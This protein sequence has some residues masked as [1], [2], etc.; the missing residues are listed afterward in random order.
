MNTPQF[1][2][3]ILVL[4]SCGGSRNQRVE[5]PAPEPHIQSRTLLGSKDTASKEA[6]EWVQSPTTPHR[7]ASAAATKGVGAKPPTEAMRAAARLQP[8]AHNRIEHF[9]SNTRLEGDAGAQE[10]VFHSVRSVAASSLPPAT[11]EAIRVQRRPAGGGSVESETLVLDVQGDVVLRTAAATPRPPFGIEVGGIL[12]DLR[13]SDDVLRMASMP[14][15]PLRLGSVVNMARCEMESKLAEVQ[16][17]GWQV[18]DL[19][20]AELG[21]YV[22]EGFQGGNPPWPFH[23]AS[24]AP[25]RIRDLRWEQG[26]EGI[27]WSAIVPVT[28]RGP[29]RA[30]PSSHD[31][32]M[33]GS[34]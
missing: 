12:I 9:Y 4:S 11:M 1:L 10:W 3:I 34:F 28:F 14:V 17:E 7:T 19:P 22:L 5:R 2:S 29:G 32:A 16:R 26:V 24:V 23:A 25:A 6:R 15:D 33:Q 31:M 21:L 27:S 20:H 18:W 13:R 30:G 8:R